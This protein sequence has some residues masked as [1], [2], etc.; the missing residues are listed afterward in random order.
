MMV[1]VLKSKLHRARVTD[2]KLHYAGSIA[3]DAE[4]ME[5]VGL[6]DY[7]AVVVADVDNGQRLETYVVPAERGS[8]EVVIM[9]A[10]AQLVNKGDIVIVFSFAWVEQG[11]LEGYKPSV[12][13]LDENNRVVKRIS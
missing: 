6:V 5:Q 7:E 12:V 10:A 13:A 9:G 11:Q 8:G 3:I 2:T 1:K 4:L